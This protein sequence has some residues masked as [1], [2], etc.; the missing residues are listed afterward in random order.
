MKKLSAIAVLI[1]LVAVASAWG[2][3]T[4]VGQPPPAAGGAAANQTLDPNGSQSIG[5]WLDE[6]YETTDLHLSIDDGATAD[7]DTTMV[8][9][10]APDPATVYEIL[11]PEPSAGTISTVRV[12]VR[13]R[14]GGAVTGDAAV[15][16]SRDGSTWVG[17]SATGGMTASYADYTIDFT[18]LSWATP[19]DLR[20]RLRSNVAFGE[21]M[22]VTRVRVE[23]NPA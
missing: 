12:R 11:F 5:D 6:E 18:S 7:D 15:D 4:V 14:F 17:M 10:F 23:I 22:Y 19:T 20:V 13:A 1:L 16:I 2:R 8:I 21:W 9:A 3:T